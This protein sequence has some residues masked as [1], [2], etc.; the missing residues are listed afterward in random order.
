MSQSNEKEPQSESESGFSREEIIQELQ[1]FLS[2]H[3][4]SLWPGTSRELGGAV[5]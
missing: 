2:I 1:E 5:K 3:V 4:G